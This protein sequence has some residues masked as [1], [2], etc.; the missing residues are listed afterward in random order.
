MQRVLSMIVSLLFASVSLSRQESVQPVANLVHR[1]ERTCGYSCAQELA[2]DL[3]GVHANKPNDAVVVHFRSKE[4]F[5]LALSTAAADYG[6]V[7]S[8]LTGVY[9]LYAGTDTA[10]TL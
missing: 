4:P 5:P 1:Y 9:R 10:L 8:I 2:I 7:I 6:Y 3:G